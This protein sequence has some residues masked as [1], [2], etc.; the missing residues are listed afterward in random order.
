[1]IAEITGDWNNENVL[2]KQRK[3]LE[4]RY[5]NKN[6]K[7]AWKSKESVL[8][9]HLYPDIWIAKKAIKEID[10]LPNDQP[11]ILWV[12]FVGPTRTI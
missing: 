7:E 1:M 11:W 5:R 9:N 3:D 8:P 10:N 4:G 6:I 12:S 2:E